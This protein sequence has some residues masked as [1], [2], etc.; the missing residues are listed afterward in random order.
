MVKNTKPAG[1]GLEAWRKLCHRWNRSQAQTRVKE[2]EQLLKN[3]SVL[4]EQLGKAMEDWEVRR[5]DYESKHET[6]L[7]D[8]DAQIALLRLCSGDLR[9]HLN[10]HYGWELST[11]ADL[12]GFLGKY[13]E[14]MRLPVP[15]RPP[16]LAAVSSRQRRQPAAA[17]AAAGLV[18]HS[19]S[20]EGSHC[21]G[22]LTAPS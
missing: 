5:A 13:L 16:R 9:H 14:R 15:G 18:Y 21:Q 4:G 7:P 1:N 2:K 20:Q 11:Y 6:T 3:Q 17:M 22:A 10:L 8:E 19:H 12:R